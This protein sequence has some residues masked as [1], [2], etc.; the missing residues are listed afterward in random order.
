[1]RPTEEKKLE[2]YRAAGAIAASSTTAR[3]GGAFTAR[4]FDCLCSVYG[5]KS[6][7]DE[8]G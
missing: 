8:C 4:H 5:F 1:M 3:A 2:S 7:V 6:F